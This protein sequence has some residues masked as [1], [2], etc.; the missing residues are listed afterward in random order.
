[1]SDDQT[2]TLRSMASSWSMVVTKAKKST[3]FCSAVTGRIKWNTRQLAPYVTSVPFSSFSDGYSCMKIPVLQRTASG[4]LLAMAEARTPDCGDFSRTDLV[5]KRSTDGGQ[6]WSPLRVMDDARNNGQRTTGLC[7]NP[8]TV[9]NVAPVQLG[10]DDL[11]HPN[12]ILAPHMRNN[13]EVWTSHSDDNGVTWSTPR[14]V[15]NVVSVSGPDCNRSMAYFGLKSPIHF[16]EWAKELGW[17]TSGPGPYKKWAKYLSGDWQFI[18]LGPAGSVQLR[19]GTMA[20]GKHLAGR[21]VVPAYHSYIRGLSGG[22]GT[23]GG[24]ALPV[25]QLYNNFALGHVIYSDDGGDTW[26]VGAKEG[27][28][29]GAV[30]G[31]MGANENQ[32]VQLKNGSLLVNS[33]SLAT[34]SSQQ[35]VQARSDNG[36]ETF[37]PSRLVPELPEPFNGCQGSIV[38]TY[39]G[40]VGGKGTLFLSHPNPSTN[41]GLAPS[42]LHGLGANV[43]LTGRDHLTI[44]RSEDQGDSYQIDELVDVGASGYSSL[45]AYAG[46]A[47]AAAPG[48]KGKPGLW[49]LYEQSDRAAD[50]LDHIGAAALIGALS[51]LNPDRFILRAFED[52]EG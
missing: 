25:S 14:K 24:V 28:G 2:A 50:S 9:G 15:P 34:G 18:G 35:R 10:A 51:V 42:I 4:A 22:G 30:A 32:I 12:R 20:G 16:L 36:G 38:S 45:Q 37:T 7:G 11:Y 13:Y 43:N 33:R 21:V 6:T 8:T 23:G 52:V 17:T 48:T 27:F 41:G 40:Q 3:F 26:S 19:K 44:W 1:M 49:L 46:A 47:S 29:G 39:G 31:S 5:V